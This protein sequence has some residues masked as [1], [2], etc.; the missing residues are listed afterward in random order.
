MAYAIR[1]AIGLVMMGATALTATAQTVEAPDLGTAIQTGSPI[2]ELRTRYEHVEQANRPNDG[3][4]F[5]LRTKLG[6]QTVKFANLQGLIE[7]EDVRQLGSEHYDTNVNGKTSYGQI[8]D[9]DVTELNRAQVVWTPASE[10][11]V[12]LGRQRINIDDQRFIGNV[13][14][15]QDEQT[16][17]AVRVDADYG[18]LDLTYAWL[19]HVNRVFAEAQDW[20][21]D[22][23]IG[24]VSYAFPEPLK[25][26]GFAYALDFTE[27]TTAA[28]RNQSNLTYGVKASGKMWIDTFKLDYAGTIAKQTDYGESLLDYDLGYG[29]IEGALTWDEFSVRANYESMEGTGTRGFTTPLATL[30]AFNGWSDAF[31]ANG[32]KTTNDGLTD[33]NIA[34]TWSPRWKWDYVFNLAFLVRYHD[35]EAERTGADLGEEWNAQV[36]GAITSRLSWLVKFADYDGPGVAPAPA[37]RQKIWLGLEWKL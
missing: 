35:F 33:A 25:L 31:L 18:R 8:F 11:T 32:V 27:P 14:W 26:S 19:A 7:F 15:R 20:N 28:V 1:T 4:A 6:W 13:G 34:F 9:P 23:H 3:D 22:S 17:D 12:T 16:Y 36:S 37:D 5:T 2:L 10:Y 30:H 29:S 24:T 21:S